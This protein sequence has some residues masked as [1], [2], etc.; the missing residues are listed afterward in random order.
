MKKKC[1]NDHIRRK[2][3][4]ILILVLSVLMISCGQKETDVAA[5]ESSSG[6]E[7]EKT[8]ETAETQDE[9]TAEEE[10]NIWDYNCQNALDASKNT[11]GTE[12]PEEKG[13]MDLM[14]NYLAYTGGE[15]EFDAS[16]E[17]SAEIILHAVISTNLINSS[18][19]PVTGFIG[20]TEDESFLDPKGW[21]N[22]GYDYG[23]ATKETADWCA[24]FIYNISEENLS[25]AIKE[26]EKKHIAY[27]YEWTN[28][29]GS[30]EYYYSAFDGKT[31]TT[32]PA[33]NL[34]QI[35]KDGDL[36]YLVFSAHVD[37]QDPVETYA[38]AEYKEFEDFIEGG[39]LQYK[40][41]SM[42]TLH[43]LGWNKPSQ[44]N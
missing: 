43:Y 30:R 23:A 15:T 19:Y 2:L 17:Q 41:E 9:V 36:Y 39:H 12:I 8:A 21:W 5:E 42:W 4:L 29:G 1:I 6:Q 16:T 27:P 3:S 7:I 28:E 11:S 26:L 20:F 31:L 24:E 14:I 37:G 10:E 44:L 35:M 34:Q 18:V 33:V 38:I 22:S 13:L 40:G 25:E 32:P